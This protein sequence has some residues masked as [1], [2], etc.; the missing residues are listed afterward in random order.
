MTGTCTTCGRVAALH[1]MRQRVIGTNKP[2]HLARLA[3]L[4]PRCWAG[5]WQE[6]EAAAISLEQH[7]GKPGPKR[8]EA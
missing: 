7:P 5:W 3:L 2:S 8:K 6:E 4:C 1:L